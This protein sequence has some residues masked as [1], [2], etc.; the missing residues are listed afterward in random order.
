MCEGGT[1]TFGS[2]NT[3][4]DRDALRRAARTN[5]AE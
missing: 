4:V 1:T 2:G 5:D 3:A